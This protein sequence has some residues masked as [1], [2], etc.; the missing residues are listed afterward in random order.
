M[1]MQFGNTKRGM[2]PMEIGQGTTVKFLVNVGHMDDSLPLDDEKKKVEIAFRNNFDILADN[3]VSSSAKTFRE[4]ISRNYPMKLNSVPVYQ[5]FDRMENGTFEYSCLSD[6][7]AEHIDSGVDMLV[8]H[9]GLTRRLA[10]DMQNSS[11]VIPLTSRGGAQLFAYM[12]NSNREN[13]YYEHWNEIINLVK[14]TGVCLALGLTLRGGSIC[15][16]LDKLYLKEMDICGELINRA[17]A[18]NVPVVIEGIGHVRLQSIPVLL[19]EVDERCHHVPIK[20]LGPVA[21][22]RLCGYDHV[23]A[24]IAAS[25]ASI[26]GASIIG[27]LL[28]SEHLG[29][30]SVEDYQQDL[31]NYKILKYLLSLDDSN[32][33]DLKLEQ[34]IS[35]ARRDRCWNLVFQNALFP[36]D[37]KRAFFRYNE[38]ETN[39]CTMCGRR[40]AHKLV[41]D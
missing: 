32:S 4:W 20:T 26:S 27:A 29:L 2:P 10:E 31:C 18:E 15:D 25:I 28:K 37:A 6:A 16:E 11:R 5:C 30:P 1:K 14:G 13:P 9:P 40:C 21:S 33:A 24:L 35:E 36:V 22:D 23:N 12:K 39:E 3:S 8:V 38:A 17:M 19:A 7:I 34:K 41:L